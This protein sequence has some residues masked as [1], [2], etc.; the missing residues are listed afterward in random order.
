MC[1]CCVGVHGNSEGLSSTTVGGTIPVPA[2]TLL[3]P[4][5]VREMRERKRGEGEGEGERETQRERQREREVKSHV[6][7]FCLSFMYIG[8]W[9]LEVGLC[10]TCGWWRLRRL[11]TQLS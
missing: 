9:M 2:H 5:N 6:C 3:Y 4:C 11:K 10:S 8:S 1:I 7:Y